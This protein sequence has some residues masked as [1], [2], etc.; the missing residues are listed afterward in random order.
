MKARSL[1]DG[2]SAYLPMGFERN[3]LSKKNR[4]DL[5]GWI[6]MST[7][8]A[9]QDV[10]FSKRGIEV[11]CAVK[12]SK[13][14]TK[15]LKETIETADIASCHGKIKSNQNRCFRITILPFVS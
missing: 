15:A 1:C 2:V 6:T 12:L 4:V 11:L 14:Q 8:F 7:G 9:L 13:A 3:P 10:I 5:Q